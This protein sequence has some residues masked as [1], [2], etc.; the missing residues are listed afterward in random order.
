[1]SQAS[2]LN[3]PVFLS[4]I[5][6]KAGPSMLEGKRPLLPNLS[7][8]YVIAK[9]CDVIATYP[10]H[11]GYSSVKIVGCVPSVIDDII[12]EPIAQMVCSDITLDRARQK[13]EFFSRTVD[14]YIW[15]I[16][17]MSQ[18]IR[19][20]MERHYGCVSPGMP[21]ANRKSTCFDTCMSMLRITAKDSPLPIDASTVMS[22]SMHPSGSEAVSAL[23]RLFAGLKDVNEMFNEPMRSMFTV[24]GEHIVTPSS[25]YNVDFQ[26]LKETIQEGTRREVVQVPYRAIATYVNLRMVQRISPQEALDALDSAPSTVGSTT[27]GWAAPRGRIVK[28]FTPSRVGSIAPS[29][30]AS[31]VAAHDTYHY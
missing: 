13:D 6:G 17:G 3:A 14:P 24:F 19:E 16:W 7:Q 18:D 5:L 20:I 10:R 27:G 4:E 29:D 31:H 9:S 30:S 26:L 28:K 8:A 21:A 15:M 23:R 2:F 1:M 12:R 25:N 22:L 11:S